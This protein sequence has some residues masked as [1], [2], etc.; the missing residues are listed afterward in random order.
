MASDWYCYVVESEWMPADLAGT[1]R[2]TIVLHNRSEAPLSGFRLGMSGPALVVAEGPHKGC[3]VVT[4][5]SNY[6][7]IAPEPGFV[8]APGASW[9]AVLTLAFPARHW[10]DGAFTAMLITSDGKAQAVLTRPATNAGATTPPKRGV[11]RHPIA[12]PGV[13]PYA[14]IPW[15]NDVAA[16]GNRTAPSGLTLSAGE[17]EGEAAAAGFADLVGH[18]FPGEALV[19][20]AEEGGY[21]VTLG[22]DASL[23]AE[24]YVISFAAGSAAIKASGRTGLLYGLITLGQMLRGARLYPQSFTFPTGGSISDAPGMEWR[25]CHFDVARQFYASGEVAQFLRTM[26]WNKLNRLHWHLSD[27]ESWRVEIDAY[28]ELTSKAA[29]RGHGMSIPPL[30]GSGPERSGGYYSKDVVRGIVALAGSL[31]IEV[32]P[33]IDVPGHCYALIQTVSTLRDQ[34]E[35]GQYF[36]IQFFDNNSLN[37]ALDRVY[38]VVE[39][40][41]AELI[42]LFPSPW[43]HVGADEVPH[44]AWDSSP[45]AQGLMSRVGG[46]EARNLQAHFLQRVQ[47]FLTSKGKITGAWEEASEGGGIDR[48]NCYL[49]G[50]RN[51]EANQRLAGEGYDVVVSPAQR[52]YLDMAN[53]PDWFEPGAAW[54]GWSSLEMSYAFVPDAGWNESERAHFK[55]VQGAIWSEPMT[56]RAVFDRLVYPRLSAIAETGWTRLEH[57][58][59]ARF[60]GSVEL[61]PA[62]YGMRE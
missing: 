56:E 54:A 27:D 1:A 58:N 48:A 15:P 32:V 38:E 53:G 41:F 10:T 33:E 28:P 35:N 62:L 51:V 17:P 42:E 45:Q 3:S 61:M 11:I 14:V 19:R 12:E 25:G 43:F 49:V 26:A 57:K 46:S 24:A 47:A 4:K 7:E 31:G 21:P 8:L 2:Y 37:P 36:S 13:A 22:L 39:T 30:L 59:W 5:L 29:W 20:S 9:T 18:L 60:V 23:G 44:D 34:G 40:I 55:G 50:W 52:Y 6:C 16:K